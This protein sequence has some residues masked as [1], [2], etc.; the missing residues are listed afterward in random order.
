MVNDYG[1]SCFIMSTLPPPPY[2]H[3]ACFFVPGRRGIVGRV[4]ERHELQGG[5]YPAGEGVERGERQ[6][7]RSVREDE[8]R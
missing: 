4:V 1:M 8:G 6:A 7:G 2:H 3:N 5:G